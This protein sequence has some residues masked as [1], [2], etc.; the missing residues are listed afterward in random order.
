[1]GFLKYKSIIFNDIPAWDTKESEQNASVC[2]KRL[3]LE[4]PELPAE[5]HSALRRRRWIPGPAVRI[6][7]KQ[8]AILVPIGAQRGPPSAA[9]SGEERIKTKKAGY[10][11]HEQRSCTEERAPIGAEKE[12]VHG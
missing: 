4:S 5:P 9:W 7:Q 10:E 8:A 11:K 2:E 6:G 12:F 3:A 1:V